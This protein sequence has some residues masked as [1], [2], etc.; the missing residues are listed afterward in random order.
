MVQF[1]FGMKNNKPYDEASGAEKGSQGQTD[2][3]L[4]SLR[5]W[6]SAWESAWEKVWAWE[7]SRDRSRFN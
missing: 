3:E 4:E 6:E 5:A 7:S 2:L 1:I